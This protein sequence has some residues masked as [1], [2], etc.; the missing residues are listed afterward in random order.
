MKKINTL[1]T[2]RT[3]FVLAFSI[4]AVLSTT[5][6]SALGAIPSPT[7]VAIP[8]DASKVFKVHSW[9]VLNVAKDTERT[10]RADFSMDVANDAWAN[11]NITI[12]SLQEIC[13]SSV[14]QFAA[15]NAIPAANY[16]FLD[17]KGEAYPGSDATAYD[18]DIASCRAES[19]DNEDDYGLA[20]LSRGTVLNS[21]L[22][23]NTGAGLLETGYGQRGIACI[24]T[25]YLDRI[26]ASCAVHTQFH[27]SSHPDR[28]EVT[29][30]QMIQNEAAAR[31][32]AFNES[33]TANYVFLPGDYNL[34]PTRAGST[35][36]QIMDAQ[37][38]GNNTAPTWPSTN[39]TTRIDHIY[40]SK[41]LQYLTSD[42]TVCSGPG[43]VTAT[44]TNDNP[45]GDHC[46]I[47]AVAYETST[48]QAAAQAIPGVP[49]AGE[50]L[51]SSSLLLLLGGTGLVAVSL[52]SWRRRKLR[53]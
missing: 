47:G 16:K 53:A 31:N 44:S 14:E 6:V 37:W 2:V 46:Y 10:Y 48:A 3:L 8:S 1:T 4:I 24:K 13:K 28:Y 12:L 49:N 36:G 22:I 17:Y 21:K 15:D 25:N 45:T 50:K 18:V 43:I 29:R 34:S 52:Y 26:L 30:N 41:S 23:R 32:Y 39:P 7:D 33:P 20:I 9:N 5:K 35:P 38:H 19:G 40:F 42:T 27:N 11:E 51:S